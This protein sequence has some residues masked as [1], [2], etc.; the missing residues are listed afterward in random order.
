MPRTEVISLYLLEENKSYP[1]KPKA[2]PAKKE[3]ARD[4]NDTKWAV[5]SLYAQW[6]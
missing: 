6:W 3:I 2:P 4:F 1:R 5:S